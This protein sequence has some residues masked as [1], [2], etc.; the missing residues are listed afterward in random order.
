VISRFVLGAARAVAIFA[1]A[2]V[3]GFGVPLAW[4]WI[5]SKIQGTSGVTHMT[6]STALAMFPGIAITYAMILHAVARA[7]T[8]RLVASGATPPPRRQSWNR[9]MR[10]DP[11]DSEP[12]TALERLFIVAASLATIACL[13][14][15][16]LYAKSPI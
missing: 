1:G 6:K 7:R 13:A 16:F 5:G 10:D 3:V 2:V 11:H 9:S 4:L 14:W 12:P 8:A 15:F